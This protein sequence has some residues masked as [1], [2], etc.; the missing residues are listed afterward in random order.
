MEF[1]KE[2]LGQIV[3]DIWGSMLGFPV[4]ARSA[5]VEANETR[6]LSA[7]GQISG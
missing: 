1:S 5:P 2:D 3:T 7:S 4:Q 6:H